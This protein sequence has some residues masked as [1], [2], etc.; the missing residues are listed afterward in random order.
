MN[1]MLPVQIKPGQRRCATVLRRS[2]IV[3][4]VRRSSRTPGHWI[5]LVEPD[6][7]PMLIADADFGEIL[8][9]SVNDD[10]RE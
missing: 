2:L 6:S 1:K 10:V 4:V 8:P 7:D 5:C 3:R 9:D